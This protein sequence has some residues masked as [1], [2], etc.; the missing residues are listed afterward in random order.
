MNQNYYLAIFQTK[1]NAVYLFSILESIGYKNFQL[2]S[3]PCSIKVGCNYGIKFNNISYK[4]IIFK[5]AS[6]IN[7][8]LVN[9]YYAEKINGRFRYIKMNF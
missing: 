3:T 8:D 1:N 7:I 5:E 6:K 9:I 4:D 2:I